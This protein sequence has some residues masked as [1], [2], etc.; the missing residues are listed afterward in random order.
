MICGIK[1]SAKACDVRFQSIQLVAAVQKLSMTKSVEDVLWDVVDLCDSLKIEYAIMGGLAV[2]IHGIPRPTYDVD[3]QLSMPK[4]ETE[5]SWEDFLIASELRGYEIPEIYRSGWRDQVGGMPL[6]KLKA[7]VEEGSSIDVDLFLN[8]TPFQN[9]V[10]SRR[11]QFPLDQRPV[12]CVTAEDL[13][14]FKL[15]ANRPRDW[16]DVA[17]ILFVQGELD[18]GYMQ[19]WAEVLSISD[20]LDKAL[21]QE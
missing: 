17:D 9:S 11:L 20:R 21:I 6:V 5:R 18:R 7:W 13:I 10:F 3:V 19:R 1:E 15:L 2:R 16:A 14:L 4:V 12:W 8:Q